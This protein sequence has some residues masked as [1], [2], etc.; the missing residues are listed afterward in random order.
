MWQHYL[1]Q[2]RVDML[3]PAYPFLAFTPLDG[4]QVGHG[5]PDD[6]WRSQES[7]QDRVDLFSPETPDA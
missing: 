4:F 1:T 2:P 6:L 7:E 3:K 5:V